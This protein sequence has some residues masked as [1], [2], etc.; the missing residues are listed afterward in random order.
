MH[1]INQARDVT[2]LNKIRTKLSENTG[3]IHE[4]YIPN[5][6]WLNRI[7]GET[8]EKF[9]LAS[10]NIE[11]LDNVDSI[12]ILGGWCALRTKCLQDLSSGYL[13]DVKTGEKLRIFNIKDITEWLTKAISFD[14]IYDAVGTYTG[15]FYTI[16]SETYLWSLRVADTIEKLLNRKLDEKDFKKIISAIRIAEEQRYKLTIEYIKS[17]YS[18]Q[19]KDLI[20]VNV[21]WD[22]DIIDEL[23]K[24]RDTLLQQVNLN[25][26]NFIVHFSSNLQ[27]N[28][29]F[30]ST[31]ADTAQEIE[32]ITKYL[33]AYSLVWMTYTGPYLEVL[34]KLDYVNTQT[35]IIIEPWSHAYIGS[36]RAR[37]EFNTLFLSGKNQY[38]HPDG[39]NSSLAFVAIDQIGDF[40]G[41]RHRT[42]KSISE[43][44]NIYNFK[45]FVETNLYA[46]SI[47]SLNLQQNNAFNLGYNYLCFGDYKNILKEM[48][49]LSIEYKNVRKNITNQSIKLEDKLTEVKKIKDKFSKKMR[50]L[51][52]SI[53]Y[54]LI[55]HFDK[56]SGSLIK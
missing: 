34:K 39:I 55:E 4:G 14:Q 22:F 8:A 11:Q 30:K 32:S 21:V 17:Y 25:L 24:I 6:V 38:L 45:N 7:I 12:T 46:E 26:H 48:I 19:Q 52:D 18:N 44:P 13:T 20:K 40:N 23:K 35:A 41:T 31:D 28:N 49:D 2:F 9:V 36:L 47:S 56:L 43:V 29:T 15:N 51:G 16:L 42:S 50:T 37:N 10:P 33:D 54:S 3:G 27:T 53:K 5:D 1:L